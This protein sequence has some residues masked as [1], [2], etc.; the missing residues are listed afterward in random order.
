MESFIQNILSNFDLCK[1]IQHADA[2]K[3]IPAGFYLKRQEI[4][5]KLHHRMVSAVLVLPDRCSQDGSALDN[6]LGDISNINIRA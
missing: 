2:A 1:I 4:F 6:P 5:A 3:D